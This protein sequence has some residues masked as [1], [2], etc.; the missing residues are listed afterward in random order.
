MPRF[1][2]IILLCLAATGL[3]TAA[4]AREQTQNAPVAPAAPAGGPVGA[5]PPEVGRRSRER[6]TWLQ[7]FR[8]ATCRTK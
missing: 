4:T 5:L 3:I 7:P 6:A 2:G 8:W 1:L